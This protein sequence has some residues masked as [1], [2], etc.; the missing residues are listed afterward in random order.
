MV[1][2]KTPQHIIVTRHAGLVTYLR[3]QFPTLATAEVV[4]HATAEQVAG[5]HVWGVLP[6]HLAALAESVTEVTMD[7]RPEERGREL[8]AE[9]MESRVTAITTYVAVAELALATRC[10]DVANQAQLDGCAVMTARRVRSIISTGVDPH[11]LT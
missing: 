4:P 7:L 5:N 2:T 11:A 6:L 10:V 9:E 1:N 8:S 3:A